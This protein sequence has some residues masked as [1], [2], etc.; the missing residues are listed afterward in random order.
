MTRSGNDQDYPGALYTCIKERSCSI[1]LAGMDFTT[2]AAISVLLKYYL[3]I[4]A[5]F[6]TGMTAAGFTFGRS[7]PDS[8]GAPSLKIV[9]TIATFKTSS[10]TPTQTT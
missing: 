1:E 6:Q 5:V 10:P 8:P 2:R 9:M 7:W 3:R 4:V